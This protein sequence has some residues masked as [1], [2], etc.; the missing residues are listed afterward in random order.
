MLLEKLGLS[1]DCD[2]ADLYFEKYGL[3]EF[4]KIVGISPAQFEKDFKHFIKGLDTQK[5]KESLGSDMMYGLMLEVLPKVSIDFYATPIKEKWDTCVIP[6][7]NFLIGIYVCFQNG[8]LLIET[9]TCEDI[10]K[11]LLFLLKHY[12]PELNE[13]WS[14]FEN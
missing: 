9:E 8:K 10:M 13:F 11:T 4:E 3:S 2:N 7:I 14:L 6:K 1:I 12:E 5:V